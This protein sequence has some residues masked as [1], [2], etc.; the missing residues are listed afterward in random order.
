MYSKVLNI[1]YISPCILCVEK[2]RGFE[3]RGL[4]ITSVLV[5]THTKVTVY[6]MG[7]SVNF[8]LRFEI[9]GV[10]TETN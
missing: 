7:S 2:V 10:G 3:S 6:H 1:Q 4:D 5:L 9:P 8:D